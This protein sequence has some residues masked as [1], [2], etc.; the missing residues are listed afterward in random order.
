MKRHSRKGPKD[1]T[2][3]E[4][5]ASTDQATSQN[6]VIHVT[7]NV[8]LKKHKNM[9]YELMHSE[10][11][12]L[13]NALN[14]LQAVREEGEAQQG[15]EMLVRGTEGIEGYLN[16]GMPL[17]CLP[18]T[19]HVEISF[20]QSKRRQEEET[21]T[22]GRPDN[23]S[24][25]CVKFFI[26]AI[27][28]RRK[29]IVKCGTLRKE[30][31]KLCVYAFKGETIKDAVCK[32]TRFLPFLEKSEWRLI[33]NMDSIVEC[34]QPVD[35]LEGKLF[36]IEVEESSTEAAA[37]QTPESEKRHTSTL[38]EGIVDQYPSLKREKEKI[39]E[40]FEKEIG[41]G[42]RKRPLYELHK[43]KFGK[44]TKNS[45]PV[46]MHKL[47]SL[48]SD[49]VGF[50][51]WN[52][53]GYGGVATCFVF[54]DLFIFTCWH[55]IKDIMGKEINSNMWADIIG[56][57]VR[58]TFGY[59]DSSGKEKNCFFVEPWFE[60]A[61]ETLDY[62]V[63]KL[64]E[65]G[66]QVPVGLYNG[67]GP[68]PLRGLIYIIGHPDGQPKTTDACVVIPHDL[69]LQKCDDHVQAR[70]EEGFNCAEFIHMYTQRSF[71]KISH[72][73]DVITYD[74][75]F[76]FGSS[77]SP[78]F[79]SQGSLVAIHNA[80]FTY[81]YYG[82]VSSIIEFGSSMESILCHIKQNRMWYEKLFVTQ[83]DVEMV[84]DEDRE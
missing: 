53:N 75:T 47:L 27:G 2:N 81:N 80:G 68:M 67:I 54:K 34:T 33:K 74:T 62:A 1:I 24:A 79:D 25:D 56:Q 32:D 66:Q 36:Q 83:Q 45:T 6:K 22:F 19:C 20:A 59:E 21:Q 46:K 58:V 14:T 15:K 52:N 37:A 78:V 49:S 44:L 31:N 51:S 4:A 11:D 41:T 39:K 57:C 60:I 55:V 43:T 70:K 9:K 69:R 29:T 8:H 18:E 5:S 50:L 16:L 30:G 48:L 65:N 82:K 77:G 7:F 17:R 61:D 23:A 35:D 13:Y 26:H 12:S 63:L 64:K 76:Y 73:P 3:I 38:K 10:K 28:K 71:K 40:S 72:N 42:K 84:S